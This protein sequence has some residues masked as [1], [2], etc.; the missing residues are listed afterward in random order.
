MSRQCITVG[1]YS[2]LLRL[3]YG[4]E[5]KQII[6]R[7]PPCWAPRISLRKLRPCSQCFGLKIPT[8]TT[9]VAI[10]CLTKT[11]VVGTNLVG[12]LAV[13]VLRNSDPDLRKLP[14][15]ISPTRENVCQGGMPATFCHNPRKIRTFRGLGIIF[16]YLLY[17]RKRTAI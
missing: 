16:I 6:V 10:P 13:C 4:L 12:L 14:R 5:E 17:C 7:T 11:A 3:V 9:L 1:A 15:S 8:P 2:M